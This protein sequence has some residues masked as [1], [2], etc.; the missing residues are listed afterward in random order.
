MSIELIAVVGNAII[1][2]LLVFTQ[3]LYNDFAK[4]PRW[5]LSNRSDQEFDEHAKRMARTIANHIENTAIFV[6]LA[7]AVLIAE[8]ATEWTGIGAGMFLGARLVYA[9][10]YVVGVPWIRSL[11]WMV[12][13]I[14]YLIVAWPL[15]GSILGTI[16]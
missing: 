3:Q 10:L 11:V 5:A 14:G 8:V 4:G 15:L 12:G 7:L 6:P 16:G 9:I 1:L 2:F 13:V